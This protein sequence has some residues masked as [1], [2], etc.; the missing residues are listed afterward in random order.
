MRTALAPALV[1]AVA[2]G[3]A[4]PAATTPTAGAW[5]GY[6]PA[7]FS[8]SGAAT[9]GAAL[10]GVHVIETKGTLAVG[11]LTGT[12]E[13]LEDVPTGRERSATVLGSMNQVDGFDGTASWEQAAGGEIMTPDAPDMVAKARTDAWITRRGYWRAGG[14][15]YR[16]LGARTSGGVRARGLEAIP[17]GGAPIE[18]WFDDA[19]LLARMSERQ[20]QDTITTDLSDWRDVGGVRVPFHVSIDQG[21]DPRN[22]V[23]LVTTEVHLRAPV[24]DATWA[25]PAID[26]DRLTFAGGVTTTELPFELINNHIYIHAKVDGQPVRMLVDTGGL[27][28]LTPAAAK[29]LG[30]TSEGAMAGSGAGSEKV[31]VGMAHG[32]SVTVGDVTLAKPVFYVIDIGRLA[33]VEGEDFDGLVGFELFARLAVR[34]DYPGRRLTLTAASAFTP[35]AGA[36]AVP[37]DMTDRTPIVQ[38]SIDGVPGRFWIDTGARTSLTTF[39]KFTRDHELEKTYKPRFEAVNGW[40][41]G[42]AVRSEPVRFHEVKIG[43]AVVHDVVGD[44]FTGDK[45]AMADPDAAANLGGGIL[46]RFVATFDY[47]H[48]TMYLEPGPGGAI[49][50]HEVYDRSGLFLIRDGA[51]ATAALRVIAVVPDGPAAKAGLTADDRVTAIDGK[52]IATRSLPEWRTALRTGAPG[53]KVKVRF[54]RK[55]AKPRDLTLI[56]ADLVP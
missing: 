54:E 16:D 46:H 22:R 38:G 11:G 8:A 18:L 13:V 37:F 34:I 42:G 30:L 1:L 55:D 7:V 20:G 4:R 39:T 33:D 26:S 21:D 53:T 19:G 45:G 29:R 28:M 48:K 43:G 17:D 15:R 24:A 23:T 12:I 50:E 49:D 10:A 35:P 51:G 14:A 32:A 44:L 5:R 36:I 3:A 27:N 6:L 56:L 9:G 40:G 47:A 25:R 41:I 31:D 2:C 52:A